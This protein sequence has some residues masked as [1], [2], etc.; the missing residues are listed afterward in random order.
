MRPHPTGGSPRS[1]SPAATQTTRISA[2]SSGAF[3]AG[4]RAN[5]C[6]KAASATACSSEVEREVPN[7]QAGRVRLTQAWLRKELVMPNKL[8]PLLRYHD[9]RAA[10]DFLTEAFGFE[11]RVVVPG[12]DARTI[13]HAQLIRGD[14]M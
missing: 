5:T 1:L 10:I 7:V 9:A 2:A 4:R 14:D 6:A 12:D 11:A 13:V 8:I 3:P